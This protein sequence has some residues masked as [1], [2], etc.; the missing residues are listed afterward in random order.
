MSSLLEAKS[1]PLTIKKN[2][3]SPTTTRNNVDYNDPLNDRF[4]VLR[5]QLEQFSRLIADNQHE[6][7]DTRLLNICRE[8]LDEMQQPKMFDSIQQQTS[9]LNTSIGKCGDVLASL[10]PKVRSTPTRQQE[11][12]NT[13]YRDQLLQTIDDVEMLSNELHIKLTQLTQIE[14][15]FKEFV[16]DVEKAMYR[17]KTFRDDLTNQNAA[18]NQ[19]QVQYA[20]LFFFQF[21]LF[22]ETLYVLV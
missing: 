9:W 19:I 22:G 17:M 4:N 3:L 16:S 18:S 5:T 20:F 8:W 7:D 2:Q 13:N 12:F 14:I 15:R 6:R 11:K 1:K 10:E 21:D